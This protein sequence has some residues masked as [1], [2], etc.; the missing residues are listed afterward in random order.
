MPPQSTTPRAVNKGEVL[1]TPQEQSQGQLAPSD[2]F[3]GAAEQLPLK[4]KNL[5][6]EKP[7]GPT[8]HVTETNPPWSELV[9]RLTAVRRE[10][11]AMQWPT[12]KGEEQQA[13]YEAGTSVCTPFVAHGGLLVVLRLYSATWTRIGGASL[14]WK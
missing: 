4:P 7:P 12:R 13:D 3:R 1:V 6:T 10:I 8:D 5:S 14:I 11:E 9:A 2:G